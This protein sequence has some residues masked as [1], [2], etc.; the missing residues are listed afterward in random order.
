MMMNQD[1]PV[2]AVNG[3]AKTFSVKQKQPGLKGSIKALWKTETQEVQAV[4]NISFT[5]QR[6]EMLAFIGP[7]RRRQINHHKDTRRNSIPHCR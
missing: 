5:L 1:Q 4:S 7:Q 3:L 2:V 6:G